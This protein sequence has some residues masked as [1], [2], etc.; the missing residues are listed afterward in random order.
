V[1]DAAM[2]DLIRPSLYGA[3]HAIL[4]L[5]AGGA[6]LETVDVVGAIC[7][8]GDFLAKD[9]ELERLQRGDYL[10][11]M[12]AGAYGYT[13]TSNYNARPRPVEVLIDGAAHSVIRDREPSLF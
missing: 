5:Q 8:S 7:E 12:T 6:E 13:L 9:R 4:P 2:S 1:V 3:Y 10:A 11:V